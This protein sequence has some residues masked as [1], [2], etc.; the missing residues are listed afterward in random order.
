M[1]VPT[2]GDHAVKQRGQT[3]LHE[4]EFSWAWLMWQLDDVGATGRDGTLAVTNPPPA[5]TIDDGDR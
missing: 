2:F 5:A 1:G 3:G 4:F